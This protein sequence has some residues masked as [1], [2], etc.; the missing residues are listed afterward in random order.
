M[1]HEK[2]AKISAVVADLWQGEDECRQVCLAIIDFL[3]SNQSKIG[4]ISY[5][6]LAVIA[7]EV[8]VTNANSILRAAEYLSGPEPHLLEMKFHFIGEDDH[9]D[10]AHD[11][12]YTTAEVK[13]FKDNNLFVHPVSGNRVADFDRHFYLFFEP[14]S[15]AREIFNGG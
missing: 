6:L 15:L 3:R 11:Y 4:Q 5:Y 2:I 10:A 1:D 14:S 13:R 8:S 9:E 12:V 7:K